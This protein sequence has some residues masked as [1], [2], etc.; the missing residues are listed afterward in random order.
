M[1]NLNYWSRNGTVSIH[2]KPMKPN[3]VILFLDPNL[4]FSELEDPDPVCPAWARS[5]AWLKRYTL[6]IIPLELIKVL[7]FCPK[8]VF[9][10]ESYNHKLSSYAWE[11][12]SYKREKKSGHSRQYKIFSVGVREKLFL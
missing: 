8:R 9:F 2:F 6:G 1:P 11:V 10:E 7:S 12:T 3:Q 4:V 5:S